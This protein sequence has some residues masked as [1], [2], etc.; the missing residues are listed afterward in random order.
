MRVRRSGFEQI[1][2]AEEFRP[3]SELAW[4]VSSPEGV[5][6]AASSDGHFLPQAPEGTGRI[7]AGG[8]V[9][10]RNLFRWCYSGV[11][12]GAGVTERRG[13]KVALEIASLLPR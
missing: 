12:A 1:A 10:A 2:I 4:P 7:Q 6:S 11:L 8:L 3:Y 13:D 5:T 9:Q